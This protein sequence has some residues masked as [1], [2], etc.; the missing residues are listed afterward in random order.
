M[1]DFIG[2]DAL[3]NLRHHLL[4]GLWPLL[5]AFAICAVAAPLMIWASRRLGMMAMPG[6]RHP[7]MKPTPLLGGVALYIGFAAAVLIF[8][9]HHKDTLGVLVVSGLAAILLICLLYTS[10]SPRD[11]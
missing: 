4:P 11:S 10:P 3:A 1:T 8:L 2:G 6:E 9:P 7:H 5:V